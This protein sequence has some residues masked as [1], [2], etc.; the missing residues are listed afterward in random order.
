LRE[1]PGS[2]AKVLKQLFW[3]QEYYI[4]DSGVVEKVGKDNLPWLKVYAHFNSLDIEGTGPR[5]LGYAYGKFFKDCKTAQLLFDDK[6]RKAKSL[7]DKLLW[8]KI[9]FVRV[10]PNGKSEQY[11]Y[12][13]GCC[14]TSINS[15][16]SLSWK[17]VKE[18]LQVNYF[19]EQITSYDSD[20]SLKPT[21]ETVKEKF[22]VR[23]IVFEN[24]EWVLKTDRKG[25]DIKLISKP[26]LI[27]ITEELNL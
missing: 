2:S 4:E 8:R 9:F 16:G 20:E 22:I 14:A 23:E 26:K 11:E 19:Y 3:L 21:V 27:Q 1:S 13:G 6:M 17:I 10:Y 12:S 24:G 5:F 7:I 18:G 25:G 15:R